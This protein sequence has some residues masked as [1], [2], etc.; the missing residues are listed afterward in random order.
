MNDWTVILVRLPVNVC[1]AV[2][3]F[4]MKIRLVNVMEG[5]L[6]K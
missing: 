2:R 3:M 4:V 1:E 5:S 6:L